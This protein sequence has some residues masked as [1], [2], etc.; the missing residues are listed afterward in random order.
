MEHD[1]VHFVIVGIETVK[2]IIDH[3][4][5]FDARLLVFLPLLCSLI[6]SDNIIGRDHI[7]VRV[8]QAAQ[9]SLQEPRFVEDARDSVHLDQVLDV[10]LLVQ[11]ILREQE[12]LMT[13]KVAS[14]PAIL[15]ASS[16]SDA[17]AAGFE[18]SY[19]NVLEKAR[20][21]VSALL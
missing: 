19:H 14:A 18:A 1:S 6:V 2:H 10:L 20:V 17:A 15:A 11:P 9:V 12:L 7:L 3:L 4:D 13:V 16:E 21:K 8:G 5:K